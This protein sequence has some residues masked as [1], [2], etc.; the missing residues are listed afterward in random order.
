MNFNLILEKRMSELIKQNCENLLIDKSLITKIKNKYKHVQLISNIT[1]DEYIK[2]TINN[3]RENDINTLL[4]FMKQPSRQNIYEQIQLELMEKYLD[5]KITRFNKDK[6]DDTKTFDG[7][8]EDEKF[9]FQC[10]YINES[11][12]SQDNQFNDLIKF[13]Q[14][15]EYNKNYLII[16]GVYGI[17][18]MYKYLQEHRLEDN[19]IVIIMD[20]KITEIDNSYQDIHYFQ[21]FYSNN[22]SLI[23]TEMKN[24]IYKH[25]NETTTIIEPFY[26]NGELIKQFKLDDYKYK[27]YDIVEPK[28]IPDN[29][30]IKDTLLNNVLINDS[31]VITNPPY[32]AKNKMNNEMKEKY[33]CKLNSNINDLYQIFIHQLIDVQV[34]GGILILPINFIFGK[35]TSNIFKCFNE[36]YKLIYLNIYE[37]QTFEKTTQTVVSL[38]FVKTSDKNIT[39]KLFRDKVIDISDKYEYIISTTF[40]SY[41]PIIKHIDITRYYNIK[42]NVVPTHIRISLIDNSKTIHASYNEIPTEHKVSDRAYLNICLDKDIYSKI[43]ERVVVNEFNKL[44]NQYRN[45]TF[46]LNL[47]SYREFNRKRLTFDEAYI[48]INHIIN[49]MF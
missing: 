24:E 18:C 2:Y 23:T 1:E 37:N 26:G 46:S 8:N 19:N 43:D 28:N 13:N 9:I 29:F 38:M 11:G 27:Y 32:L 25:V 16:S 10:K 42:N 22:E 17:K 44:I 14:K 48:L 41:F 33:K 15:H 49:I 47:T 45:E 3:I 12:G 34:I 20:D 30:E 6:F 5:I 4:L 40:E 31:F 36:K 21:K 7:I 35:T 39:V